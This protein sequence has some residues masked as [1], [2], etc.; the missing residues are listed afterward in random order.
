MKWSHDL[1]WLCNYFSRF[2]CCQYKL[3]FTHAKA[4]FPLLVLT[5]P[6]S[7][8][9]NFIFTFSSR[10]MDNCL[11]KLDSIASLVSLKPRIH[12]LTS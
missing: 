12:R 9:V 3:C 2:Y 1:S 5:V 6:W 10:I 8:G 4:V 11:Y 7:L